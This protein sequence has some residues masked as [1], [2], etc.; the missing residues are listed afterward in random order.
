MKIAIV[1]LLF[2]LLGFLVFRLQQKKQQHHLKKYRFHHSITLKLHTRYPHLEPHQINLIF[3]ALRDYFWI[4]QKAKKKYISMPSQAVDE[5][6]HEFILSTRS[7]TAFCTKTFGYFLHHNPAETMRS[8]AAAYDG[9]K[10]T[11]QLACRKENIDPQK[12][13]RLPLL[14]AIDAML[15]IPDGFQYSLH[16]NQRNASNNTSDNASN[17]GLGIYCAS[18]IGCSGGSGGSG[19]MDGIFSDSSIDSGC[20]SGCGGD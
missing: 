16:C 15:K 14:F 11:W 4:C 12:P 6:W 18:D 19:F 13:L 5:A 2:L 17:N 9:I 1:G 7:Y 8:Q 10:L 3:T 20:G